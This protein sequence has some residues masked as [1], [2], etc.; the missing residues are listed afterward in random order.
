MILDNPLLLF[1]L[2]DD[3]KEWKDLDVNRIFRLQCF[4]HGGI[5]R[6]VKTIQRLLEIARTNQG[7]S[8]SPPLGLRGAVP[9]KFRVVTVPITRDGQEEGKIF[10]GMRQGKIVLQADCAGLP[11]WQVAGSNNLLHARNDFISLVADLNYR[12]TGSR[13]SLAFYGVLENEKPEFSKPV[14]ELLQLIAQEV[15]ERGLVHC[16]LASSQ[17]HFAPSSSDGAKHSVIEHPSLVKQDEC[18]VA[19]LNTFS[20]FWTDVMQLV[21]FITLSPKLLLRCAQVCKAW[22]IL[23][24]HDV[25]W[26]GHLNHLNHSLHILDQ[27]ELH[28]SVGKIVADGLVTYK[29]LY[30]VTYL[31]AL[32]RKKEEEHGLKDI[33]DGI[34][35]AGDRAHER[36]YKSMTAAVPTGRDMKMGTIGGA[37]TVGSMAAKVGNKVPIGGQAAKRACVVGGAVIGGLTG[38]LGG[39]IAG[40]VSAV[41][42][43]FRV[44][45]D[46][47]D[48]Q[49][50]R[51]VSGCVAKPLHS[52]ADILEETAHAINHAPEDMFGELNSQVSREAQNVT[53]IAMHKLTKSAHFRMT[54]S[55]PTAAPALNGWRTAKLR[56]PGSWTPASNSST[57]TFTEASLACTN[58]PATVPE[59]KASLGLRLPPCWELDCRQVHC[60]AV[61]RRA[62]VVD[63]LAGRALARG[64]ALTLE[65]PVALSDAS[66]DLDFEVQHGGTAQNDNQPAMPEAAMLDE[67]DVAERYPRRRRMSWSVGD[68]RA[69]ERSHLRFPRRAASF[70]P[71]LMR[72]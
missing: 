60:Q 55:L 26:I 18:K 49:V 14:Q 8:F 45:G 39:S 2:V 47:S 31:E 62:V 10:S 67:L 16:E 43:C 70:P 66:D 22:S 54:P 33:G 20:V 40:T 24:S 68:S 41:S 13:I 56:L 12:L 59:W 35:F 48:R 15:K 4:R 71:P 63:T 27:N 42:I 3:D 21:V 57:L 34:S 23:S 61:L 52:L 25:L 6:S 65:T 1:T 69:P 32:R 28:A 11:F 50:P 72:H 53:M 44:A 29:Y 5:G 64:V 51:F 7:Q 17:Q 46:E 36:T 19:Y 30:K 9:W 58:T 38:A 37:L